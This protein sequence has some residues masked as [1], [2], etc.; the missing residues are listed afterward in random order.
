MGTDQPHVYDLPHGVELHEL[1]IW[2]DPSDGT[3]IIQAPPGVSQVTF[4][5]QQWKRLKH[6]ID[7]PEKG[8]PDGGSD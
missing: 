2:K 1:Q 6:F 3:V 7:G 8:V 5:P 4:T